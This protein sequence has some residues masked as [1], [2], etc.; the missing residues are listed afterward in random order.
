MRQYKSTGSAVRHARLH[1][2][3]HARLHATDTDK[4]GCTTTHGAVQSHASHVS[5]RPP[6]ARRATPCL[7]TRECTGRGHRYARNPHKKVQPQCRDHEQRG[8]HEQQG[9]HGG[10]S[11]ES[12]GSD[13]SMSSNKTTSSDER[14]RPIVRRARTARRARAATR[15]HARAAAATRSRRTREQQRGGYEGSSK[16]RS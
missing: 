8:E 7:T 13:A 1:V 14:H 16:R 11:E 9:E 10:S 5:T 12:M 6:V 3:W 15:T 2:I 4:A